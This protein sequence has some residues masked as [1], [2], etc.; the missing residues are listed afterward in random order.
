MRPLDGDQRR[1]RRLPRAHNLI[2][3]LWPN[4]AA[5]YRALFDACAAQ[6]AC[7][8]AYPDLRAKFT[9]TVRRLDAQPL[10]AQ[11]PNPAGGPA[12]TVL[13]DGYKLANLLNVLAL[14][15]GSLTDAPAILHAVATGDPAPAAQALLQTISPPGL[16][17]FGLQYG[18][19]CREHTAFTNPEKMQAEAKRA[20]PDFPDRVLATPPQVPRI[21]QDCGIWNAGRADPATARPT[22]SDIPALLLNGTLD[23]STPPEWAATAATRVVEPHAHR[24][25]R[26]AEE[27]RAEAAR[28]DEAE[29]ATGTRRDRG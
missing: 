18:V 10:T 22:R 14:N 9:A 20:L 19:V 1:Y 3:G 5:G 21:F 11:V 29:G 6:A 17:G 24:R 4:A 13:L 26:V 2:D 7:A 27:V 23:G 8:A 15:P 12:I 16:N 25:Q 28:R